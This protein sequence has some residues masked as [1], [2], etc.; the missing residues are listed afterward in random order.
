MLLPLHLLLLNLQLLGLVS[1]PVFRPGPTNPT[2]VK[3]LLLF[4]VVSSRTSIR[5]LLSLD[6][7]LGLGLGLGLILGVP[8]VYLSTPIV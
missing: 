8:L 1:I 5:V 7:P 2:Q 3:V 6:L 4:R